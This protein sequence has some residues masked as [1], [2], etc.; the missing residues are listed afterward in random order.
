[1]LLT[2]AITVYVVVVVLGLALLRSAALADRDL[3]R[4]RRERRAARHKDAREARRRE[5]RRR[6]GAAS[7]VLTTAAA[8]ACAGGGAP[9]ASASAPRCVGPEAATLCLINSARRAHDLPSL[10]LD[11]RLMLAARRHSADMVRRGYFSHVSPGGARIAQR[12]RRV[13]Y[14]GVCAWRAGETLAWGYGDERTPA[15][16]V[17][18][19]LASPPH[20]RVLLDPG[21]RDAGVGTARGVPGGGHDGFTYTA[22]LGRRRC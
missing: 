6:V 8:G 16:R 20:R 1:M 2:V 4:A 21:Y 5:A 9:S 15:S 3:E 19:W 7:L 12:L 18:A 10:R 14:V 17:A 11:A 22:E 13:G